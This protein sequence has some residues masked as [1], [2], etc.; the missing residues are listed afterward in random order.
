M[1]NRYFLHKANKLAVILT[2]TL[3]FFVTH[4]ALTQNRY[5]TSFEAQSLLNSD[6]AAQRIEPTNF[7]HQLLS[8]LIF[9]LTNEERKA[10]GIPP[11]TYAFALD[12]AATG[13]SKDMVEH[14]FYAHVSPVSG[15]EYMR[16]R[17]EAVGIDGGAIAEN[18]FKKR[19][20]EGV[21][22]LRFAHSTVEG[23]MNSKGHR[24]NILNPKYRYLG[25]GTAFYGIDQFGL[26]VM[27]T[28]NFSS[29]PGTQNGLVAE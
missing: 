9:H 12:L 16:D 21:S 4:A 13:H 7:D 15:K 28:Q 14:D 8:A 11:L 26:Q 24:K 3:G 25:C 19:G 23:W 29:V 17:M 5:C 22:Y 1:K 6:L 10:E 20:A 18:I 27:C 2:F